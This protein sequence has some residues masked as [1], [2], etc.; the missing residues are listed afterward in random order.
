MI[1]R[2]I[3]REPCWWLSDSQKMSVGLGIDQSLKLPGIHSDATKKRP[4]RAAICE[5]AMGMWSA[6]S[7]SPEWQ[8]SRKAL[9]QAMVSESSEVFGRFDCSLGCLSDENERLRW[10]L[11]LLAFIRNQ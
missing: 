3:W 5:N 1:P 7:G 2:L 10:A 11:S 6:G 8:E 4:K 9:F